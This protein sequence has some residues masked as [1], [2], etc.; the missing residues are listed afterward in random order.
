MG[1]T[2]AQAQPIDVT[3]RQLSDGNGAQGGGGTSL[4]TSASDLISFY[5]KT[6]IPQPSQAA[7]AAL[8]SGASANGNALGILSVY[9]STQ[10]PATVAANTTAEQSI[11]VTGILSTDMVFINKPTAQ[12]GLVLTKGRVFAANTVKLTFANLTAATLTPTGS[13][14]YVV[15]GIAANLQLSQA[16][17]PVSV[18]ANTTVEQTFTVTGLD[19]GMMVEVN[20]PTTQAGLAVLSARVSAKNQIAITFLNNTA[21]AL[22]PTAGESYEIL[23]INGLLPATHVVSYGINGGTLASVVTNTTAELTFTE[24][25]IAATDIVCGISKPSLQAGLAVVGGRVSASATIKALFANV[26]AAALTPTGSE[27]YLVTTLKPVLSA[28]TSTFTVT[29]TPVSVAANTSAEQL[30]TVTG[31]VSGQPVMAVPNYYLGPQGVGFGGV[32]ASAANQIGI[33]FIN[34]TTA[35]L[36]PA[37]GTWTVMQINQTLPTA[38]NYVQLMVS[39]IQ[40]FAMSLLSAIRTALANL[41]GIAGS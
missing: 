6:P 37:A 33:N 8:A 29:V 2:T 5:N 14:A 27:T 7:Q 22:T 36:T 25:G 23:A 30:V 1:T 10:T 15:G 11:T 38:S 24:A 39:P 13:E 34:A 20:K 9:T 40:T 16:L 31:I 21:A 19:V 41:G 4:G 26:T 18:A 3:I 32:R 28:L 35:A 17:T 12:A